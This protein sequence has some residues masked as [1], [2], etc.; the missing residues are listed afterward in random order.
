MMTL[1]ED[2]VLI[3]VEAILALISSMIVKLKYRIE[4]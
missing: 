3:H 4:Q 1:M 2:L